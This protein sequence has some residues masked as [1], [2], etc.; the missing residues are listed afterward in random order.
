MRVE[1]GPVSH[2]SA[3]AWLDYA[4]LILAEVRSHPRPDELIAPAL[5]E[6]FA[7]LVEQWRAANRVGDC[8]NWETEQSSEQVEFLIK[9]LYEA[10]LMVERLNETGAMPL[11]PEAADEFHVTLVNEVLA[12]LTRES[13]ASAHFADTLR[14]EWSVAR[15]L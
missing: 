15:L 7:E 3:E 4:T 10:G 12:A 2:E 14:S 9:A 1:F 11:R 5:V 13:E 8:F 6:Q